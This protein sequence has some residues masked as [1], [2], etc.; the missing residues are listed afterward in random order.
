MICVDMT[1]VCTATHTCDSV[2][3]MALTLGSNRR[4]PELP[5]T[6]HARRRLSRCHCRL[7]RAGRERGSPLDR[8]RPVCR[9]LRSQMAAMSWLGQQTPARPSRTGCCQRR[10]HGR[11]T[12]AAA[13][14]RGPLQ[15]LAPLPCLQGTWSM[16]SQLLCRDRVARLGVGGKSG[17]A[18]V[19]LGCMPSFG[20]FRPPARQGQKLQTRLGIG[21][22]LPP[23]MYSPNASPVPVTAVP[24]PGCCS[25]AAAQAAVKGMSCSPPAGGGVTRTVRFHHLLAGPVP[26]ACCWSC[27]PL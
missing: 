3:S 19:V 21:R 11:H 18:P 8:C 20:G 7:G 22:N 4:R 16:S 26:A 23:T 15:G 10:R 9:Q 14:G 17:W 24:A 5:G 27:L 12:A 2:A 1:S 13:P 6:C 25:T